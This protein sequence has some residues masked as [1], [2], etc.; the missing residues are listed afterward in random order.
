[1]IGIAVMMEKKTWKVELS[2]KMKEIEALQASAKRSDRLRTDVT[3]NAE[4]YLA[5]RNDLVTEAT[6]LGT[7]VRRFNIARFVAFAL[8][9]LIFEHD[10]MIMFI[11][12]SYMTSTIDKQAHELV[13]MQTELE[14]A[15]D[16]ASH[17]EIHTKLVKAESKNTAEAAQAY[18]HQLQRS[19][20]QN[21]QLEQKLIEARDKLAESEISHHK[22]RKMNESLRA[23]E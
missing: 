1:L 5:E 10:I 13:A 15:I 19:V 7:Q 11:Q 8:P 12:V 23:G 21:K 4:Q 9:L 20:L 16:K 17:S 14:R 2:Q 22:L 18:Q 3:L 6:D